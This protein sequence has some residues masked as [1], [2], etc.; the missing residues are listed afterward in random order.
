[1]TTIA[2]LGAGGKMGCRLAD[3]LKDSRF[4]VAP[5]RDPPRP[6]ASG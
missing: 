1:M 5:R 4:E 2:L 3:N 6:A